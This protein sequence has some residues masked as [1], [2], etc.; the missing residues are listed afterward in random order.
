LINKLFRDFH[1]V[2]LSVMYDQH[3]NGAR[4]KKLKLGE[5]LNIHELCDTDSDP[6]D[7]HSNTAVHAALTACT[8]PAQRLRCACVGRKVRLD[9]AENGVNNAVAVLWE[10]LYPHFP[11]PGP[12]VHTQDNQEI[13]ASTNTNDHTSGRSTSP[14]TY[15]TT[16]DGLLRLPNGMQIHSHFDRAPEETVF[17]HEEIFV[18]QAYERAIQG[19]Q[20]GDLVVDVGELVLAKKLSNCLCCILT[21]AHW[22]VHFA[23]A[24][25]GMF[26]LYAARQV[27]QASTG[28]SP[29]Q[30]LAIEPMRANYAPLQRNLHLHKVS[31]KAYRCAVGRTSS[32][33]AGVRGEPGSAARLLDTLSCKDELLATDTECTAQKVRFVLY[34]VRVRSYFVCH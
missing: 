26:A 3:S 32:G 6:P 15:T 25:I 24:N 22:C 1:T 28:A 14:F 29:L 7:M 34:K 21:G 10:C 9:P 2:V 23:G 4:V 13:F 27:I 19:L 31:H 17:L 16:S 18:R 33:S 8:S 30:I 20:P 11:Y 5:S 12:P